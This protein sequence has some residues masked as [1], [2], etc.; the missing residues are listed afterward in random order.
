MNVSERSEIT[1]GIQISFLVT[2]DVIK[3]LVIN[4]LVHQGHSSSGSVTETWQIRVLRLPI[5]SGLKDNNVKKLSEEGFILCN[6]ELMWEMAG[7]R[8]FLLKR[9]FSPC[10]LQEKLQMLP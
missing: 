5:R 2:K 3:A 10:P 9:N 4:L 1:S 6:I 8:I 7:N